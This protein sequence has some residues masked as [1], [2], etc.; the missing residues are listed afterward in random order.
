MSHVCSRWRDAA[1]ATPLL[2][3]NIDVYSHR[4]F[5]AVSWYL[6]HSNNCHIDVHIDIWQSIRKMNPHEA[7]LSV[8]PTLD[9]LIQHSARWRSLFVFASYRSTTSAILLHMKDLFTPLLERVSIVDDE[10]EDEQGDS[11]PSNDSFPLKQRFLSGGAPKLTTLNTNSL[12]IFP[13]L[14]NVVTLH[15]RTTESFSSFDINADVI[16]NLITQ[17]P[18]LS[19][20]SI[21]GSFVGH[22]TVEDITMPNLRCLWFSGDILPAKFLTTVKLPGLQSLY[23]DCPAYQVINM[24][25]GHV[26]QPTFPSLK[27]LTLQGFDYYSSKKFAQVFSTI[28]ALH[29][30]YC[31][32]FHVTFLKQTLL[33]D[34]LSCWQNL[35]VVAFRTTR[36]TYAPKF[37]KVLVELVSERHRGGRPIQQVLLDSDLLAALTTRKSVEAYTSVE[38]MREDN[39]DDPWWIITHSDTMPWR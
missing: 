16:A 33:D 5:D 1:L 22:W 35:R 20:L 19:S 29:L 31:N 37:S 17:C 6:Q 11:T 24:I 30:A 14:H 26:P 21:H 13:P 15:L 38:E 12:D 32:S 28:E 4:S 3:K 36:E 23:L 8:I 7:T 25:C 27:Y 2:W 39:Y 9:L 10:L 34:D 18:A